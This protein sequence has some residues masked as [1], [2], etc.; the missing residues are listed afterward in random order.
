MDVHH[1]FARQ[2]VPYAKEKQIKIN[3]K[4]P[5]ETKLAQ[6][7]TRYACQPQRERER[8][9]RLFFFQNGC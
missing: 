7:H 8:N 1:T 9:G 6:I 2:T 5:N 4:P 3:L